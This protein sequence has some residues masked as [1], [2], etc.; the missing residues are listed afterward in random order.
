MRLLDT[1]PTIPIG[2]TYR[3]GI[4]P[5]RHGCAE[6]NA[7]T[8]HRYGTRYPACQQRLPS[9]TRTQSSYLESHERTSRKKPTMTVSVPPPPLDDPTLADPLEC[10]PLRWGMIGCG[11]VSHDFTQ[12][13]KH[14]PTQ[15]VVACS[16]RS[17][18][19]ARS[20][21]EKHGI[22]NHC[23]FFFVNSLISVSTKSDSSLLTTMRRNLC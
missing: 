2:I 9:A 19:S 16:A 18:D 7:S 8:C 14:L 17:V 3:Y 23:K 11:R 12:C 21:A 5:V 6:K 13:L 20:F 10:P 22:A 4:V 15:T 1:R